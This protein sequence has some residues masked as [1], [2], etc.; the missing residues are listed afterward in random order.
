MKR[1]SSSSK[2]TP[3]ALEIARVIGAT[4]VSRT[5]SAFSLAGHHA[6]R[7]RG[8]LARI[9]SCASAMA[10]GESETDLRNLLDSDCLPRGTPIAFGDLRRRHVGKQIDGENGFTGFLDR[11]AQVAATTHKRRRLQGRSA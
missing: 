11:A 1:L 6:R 9:A 4:P 5:G 7:Q 10:T 3:P 8:E 2:V